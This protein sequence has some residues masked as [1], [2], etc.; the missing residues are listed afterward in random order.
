MR[1]LALILMCFAACASSEEE[2]KEP[3]PAKAEEGEV[4]ARGIKLKS[5]RRKKPKKSSNTKTIV[6]SLYGPGESWGPQKTMLEISGIWSGMAHVISGPG[7]DIERIE[8]YMS[9]GMRSDTT[10]YSKE[11]PLVFE[12]DDAAGIAAMKAW[13]GTFS[14]T[15][16]ADFPTRDA[17]IVI[18]NVAGQEVFRWN[19]WELTPGTMKK[20]PNGRTRYTLIQRL[21]P[22]NQAHWQ[23]GSKDPFGSEGVFN[24]ATDT[25]TEIAGISHA[26]FC[27]VV[28][29]DEQKLTITLTWDFNEGHGIY[30]WVL[31]TISGIH[32]KRA[33][34]VIQR[35]VAGQETSRTNYFECLPIRY[36]QMNYDVPEKA[37]GRVVIAYGSSKLQQ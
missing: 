18:R 14:K 28:K 30:D 4:T 26:N 35:N 10:G 34:S 22:D 5:K 12:L 32:D 24:P 33:M 23:F 16:A 2:N 15:P 6:V 27:P 21:L 3:E 11:H 29:V 7:F 36:E 19:T 9:N 37:K 13:Y 20:M 17:A 1:S 31:Q 8:G 25:L